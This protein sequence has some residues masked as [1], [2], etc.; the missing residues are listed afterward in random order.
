MAAT[1]VPIPIPGRERVAPIFSYRCPVHGCLVGLDGTKM[2]VHCCPGCLAE[3]AAGILR[4]QV[5]RVIED[6][7]AEVRA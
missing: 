5:K 2:P 1:E 4:L 3:A 6:Q 7:L